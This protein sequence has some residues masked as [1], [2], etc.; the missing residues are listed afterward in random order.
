MAKT[1]SLVWAQRREKV[2]VTFQCLETT[3]VSVTL[4]DG[5]LSLDATSKGTTYKLEN[6]PLWTEIEVE[7]SK[8][9]KNDRAV[10]MSLK[11]KAPDW[12]DGLTTDKSLKKFIKTDFGKFCEEDDPEYS[13]DV[14]MSGMGDE[15]GMGGGGMGGMPGMGGMGGMP[16]MGGMG[17]MPG[18]GGM[19]MAQMMQGMGGMGDMMGGMGG[20]FDDDDEEADLGDLDGADAPPPLESGD[21]PPPLESAVNPEDMEEVD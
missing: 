1:P 13:G 5:L 6:M 10:V 21:G 11:K 16:G 2:F 12:W 20:D 7:E 14:S 15:M 3:D 17:G 8:W 19:D 9:F 18:M 4:S